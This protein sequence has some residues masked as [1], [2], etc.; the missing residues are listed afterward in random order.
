MSI[1]KNFLTNS[2]QLKN[3]EPEI[4]QR[5]IK[6]ISEVIQKLFH[7][8]R[9]DTRPFRSKERIN[10]NADCPENTVIQLNNVK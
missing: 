9:S 3:A 5:L 6:N 1:I 2:F 4:R 10:R 7:A 8:Y